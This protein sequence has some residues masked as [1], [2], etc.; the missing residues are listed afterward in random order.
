MLSIAHLSGGRIKKSVDNTKLRTRPGTS[1]TFN[2]TVTV[3]HDT[4]TDSGW[5]GHRDDRRVTN[6]NERYFHRRRTSPTLSTDPMRPVWSTGRYECDD[7]GALGAQ[8]STYTCTYT[9]LAATSTSELDTGTATWANRRPFRWTHSLP[10]TPDLSA[11]NTVPVDFSTSRPDDRRRLRRASPTRWAATLG[12]V[13]HT[14]SN[15]T[16]FNYPDTG[17]RHARVPA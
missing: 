10:A 3:T 6:P 12:T 15:P 16:T 2:Y 13:S 11:S 5:N 17:Y 4:G 8:T 1:A 7:S 9:A 14:D